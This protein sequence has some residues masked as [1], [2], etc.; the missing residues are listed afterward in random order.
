MLWD[1][2]FIFKAKLLIKTTNFLIMLNVLEIILSSNMLLQ[3]NRLL[4]T[5]I[6]V[7]VLELY[8]N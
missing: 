8:S 5:E 7:F 1:Y 2:Y 4:K 6:F 3:H